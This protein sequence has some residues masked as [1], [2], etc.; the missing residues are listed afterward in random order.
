MQTSTLLVLSLSSVMILGQ[1]RDRDYCQISQGHTLCRNKGVGQLCG[2]VEERGLSSREQDEVTDYHNRLRSGVARGVTGQ[3]PAS[4]ML[5]MHW[6]PEL[7]RVAQ[8][9]ADQCKFSHDCPDCRRVQRFKVGQNIYQ[10]FTTRTGEGVK[11]QAAIDSWYNEIE[12]F[13]ASSVASYSFSQ[14]TGHYSQLVWAATDRIGC[15]VT[16]FRKGRFNARLYVCNYGTTGNIVRRSVYK[17]GT[18]CSSCPC[19]FQ[20]SQHYPGLC[21]ASNSTACCDNILCMFT[22]PDIITNEITDM[23][24]ETVGSVGGAAMET[25]HGAMHTAHGVGHMAMHTANGVGSL[26]MDTMH[27]VGSLAMQ[28]AHGVGQVAVGTA[29]TVG[30]LG[31]DVTTLVQDSA[32]LVG[33]GFRPVTDL[34]NQGV[35]LQRLTFQQF[36]RNGFFGKK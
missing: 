3:P 29:H 25:L 28:G 16:Q 31:S 8:R 12:L 14:Q 21:S 26:A 2:Q 9:L 4:D 33:R 36:L 35:D 10:S 18:A 11:W 22:R 13:P 7:A 6:D 5:E 23:T 17:Q 19:N 15:G 1:T 27:G 24:M 20:C 34:V 32:N 30:S